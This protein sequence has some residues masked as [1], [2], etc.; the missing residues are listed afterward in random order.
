MARKK[1]SREDIEKIEILAGY[2]MPMERIAPIFGMDREVFRENIKKNK[3]LRNAIE[4]GKSQALFKATQSA[5][6]RA[7]GGEVC[8][9]DKE[10]NPIYKATGDTTMMIFWL[11]TQGRWKEPQHVELSGPNGGPISTHSLS[12]E[13]LDAE[14]KRLAKK[15]IKH[16]NG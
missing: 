14:I 7:F 15:I 8:G 3:A 6:E 16:D 4:K 12:D 13:D 1:F 9:V 5:F 10:G 11:K 2:G